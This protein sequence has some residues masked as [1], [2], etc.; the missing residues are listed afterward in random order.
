VAEHPDRAAMTATTALGLLPPFDVSLRSEQ[1]EVRGALTSLLTGL[2]PLDLDVEELN[3][4]ELVVAEILNNIVEHAYPPTW[5]RSKISVTCKQER[6]G[7]HLCII[8]RGKAMPDNQPPIGMSKPRDVE[9]SD[10]PEGGFGWFLIQYLAKD[11]KYQRSGQQNR[12]DLRIAVALHA[13]I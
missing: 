11:I 13:H 10:M 7:L 4:V 9:I 1:A 2:A 12:L 3:I 6:N 8:D 5:P